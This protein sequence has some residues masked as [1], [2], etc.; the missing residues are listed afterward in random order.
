[1]SNLQELD[2]AASDDSISNFGAAIGTAADFAG[3]IGGVAALIDVMNAFMQT[4]QDQLGMVQNSINQLIGAQKA[5]D[6]QNR[7]TE[8]VNAL[9]TMQGVFDGLKADLNANLNAADRNSR[10]ETCSQA[11]SIFTDP[12]LSPKATWSAPY[13]DLVYW[14]DRPDFY[15]SGGPLTTVD[16]GYGVVSPTPDADGLVFYYNVALP[17]F[18]RALAIWVAEAAALDPNY[19]AD[20]GAAVLQP[21]V[22][23]LNWVHDTIVGQGIQILAPVNANADYVEWNGAFLFQAAFYTE[24][25]DDP[26]ILE[27][28]IVRGVTPLPNVPNT[29]APSGVNLEFGAIEL[30]SGVSVMAT[31]SLPF[32]FPEPAPNLNRLNAAPPIDLAPLGFVSW[33]D[34]SMAPYNKFQVR[35]MY[36]KIRLYRDF[37]IIEIWNAINTFNSILSL[38]LLSRPNPGD[39]SFL[40][41]C[42]LLGLDRLSAIKTFLITTPPTDTPQGPGPISFRALLEV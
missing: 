11:L 7:L 33:T 25:A 1:M 27:A 13:S 37:N 17:S 19:I 30:Y 29:N 3:A 21:A 10:I 6:L 22:N 41:L 20:F 23:T 28:N 4:G 26:Q 16:L 35:C 34:T 42:Q 8:M 12:S 18:L 15:Y 39:W 38:P 31:Y 9:A 32:R 40:A 36:E 24:T 2:D 14:D 5:A